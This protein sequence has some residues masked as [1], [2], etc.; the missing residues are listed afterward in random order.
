MAWAPNHHKQITWYCPRTT[1]HNS[2]CVN[3]KSH[4]QIVAVWLPHH[5]K[6]EI[7]VVWL[8][9]HPQQIM[10]VCLPQCGHVFAERSEH[11]L[12]YLAFF[13]EELGPALLCP[14]ARPGSLWTRWP[15]THIFVVWL[16]KKHKQ[17][18]HC[19]HCQT[20]HP[21]ARALYRNMT[22]SASELCVCKAHPTSWLIH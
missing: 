17:Y 2:D 1:T 13:F 5:Y 7:V 3:P 15:I 21:D 20:Q 10:V 22:L 4:K 6:K 8:P 16:P 12:T 19:L 11:H 9:T 18:H 14:E